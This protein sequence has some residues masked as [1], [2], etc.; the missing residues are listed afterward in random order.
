MP[1]IGTRGAAS[2]RGFGRFSGGGLDFIDA[3]AFAV[4]NADLT[5]NYAIH[6]FTP[7]TNERIL[8]GMISGGGGASTAT[9]GANAGNSGQTFS[10]GVGGWGGNGAIV[11]ILVL[12][13]QA[14]LISGGNGGTPN[15]SDYNSPF[16][17]PGQAA[18]ISIASSTVFTLNGGLAGYPSW[19]DTSFY[20]LGTGYTINNPLVARLHSFGFGGG[21]NGTSNG[22]YSAAGEVGG[23]AAQRL[24]F[25]TYTVTGGGTMN[26]PGDSNDWQGG[27]QQNTGVR[28]TS[29][30]PGGTGGSGTVSGVVA[31]GGG[32]GSACNTH[33][34]ADDAFGGN[35]GAWGGA[36]GAGGFYRPGG[37][38]AQG[39]VFII[40]RAA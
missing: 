5:T 4:T 1:L 35:G 27:A 33:S 26:T 38:G 13:G 25:S 10:T 37:S 15:G 29:A 8:V 22:R 39:R 6:S 34:N 32:G 31:A 16:A 17:Q 12:A 19:I 36:G 14:V 3:S 11:Q 40:R 2:S 30:Q 24:D 9:W 20:S 7:T 18:T 23:G 28:M 21:P